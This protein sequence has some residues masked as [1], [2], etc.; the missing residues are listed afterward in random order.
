[1]T[2][3]T[4]AVL[5]GNSTADAVKN[6]TA[7]N[8][9][10]SQQM[11]QALVDS[12]SSN[13]G[14]FL[15]MLQGIDNIVTVISNLATVLGSTAAAPPPLP[16][17]AAAT[18]A[19]TMLT[20][21]SGAQIAFAIGDPVSASSYSANEQATKRSA[22]L[23]GAYDT[24]AD[25]W[26]RFF[27]NNTDLEARYASLIAS[28]AT[29]GPLSTM[30]TNGEL[31]W[32]WVR[33]LYKAGNWADRA[34]YATG[35]AFLGQGVYMRPTSFPIGTMAEAGPEAIMPL[36]QMPGGGLGVRTAA[37]NDNSSSAEMRAMRQE[38]QKT[39][40]KLASL[41]TVLKAG[42]SQRGAIAMQMLD[43]Q[44]KVIDGLSATK[45]ELR[46]AR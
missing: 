6:L 16:A 42:N 45:K 11:I 5:T 13:S 43:K 41:E 2:D 23:A 30:N 1:V 40:D 14:T 36:A 18:E 3:Q 46:A 38:L 7:L 44:D 22:A 9:V 35:A 25:F 26:N 34:L 21:A 33:D 29:G 10:Y 24:N 15:A 4:G 19:A 12:G 17:P 27:D 39:N 28:G 8:S 20:L 31:A 37:S 32:Q